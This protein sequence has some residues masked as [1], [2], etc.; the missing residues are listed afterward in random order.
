MF[1]CIGNGLDLVLAWFE[2]TT[3]GEKGGTTILRY[4]VWSWVL[5]FACALC[6]ALWVYFNTRLPNFFR[7]LSRPKF[8]LS[9]YR[10][11]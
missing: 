2:E 5:L 8:R 10:L 9:P 11:P 1:R 6:V 7:C 4:G 3:A